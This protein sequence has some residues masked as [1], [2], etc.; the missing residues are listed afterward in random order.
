MTPLRLR[1]TAPR[2][3]TWPPART[4]AT[5]CAATTR[6][7]RGARRAGARA[8]PI[9]R[10]HRLRARSRRSGQSER[11]SARVWPCFLP[12]LPPARS[13]AAAAAPLARTR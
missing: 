11:A 3:L 4:C 6:V 9:G 13:R 2:R 1:R 12:S 8:A 7:R 10:T 5:C